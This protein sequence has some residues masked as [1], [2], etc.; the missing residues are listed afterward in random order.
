MKSVT[1]LFRGDDGRNYLFTFVLISTLFL[2]WGFCNSMIDI[3]DKH[4]QD[5]LHLTRAQSA[6]VQFSHY[7]GYFLIALPAGWLSRKLGYKGGILVGLGVVALGGFWFV[8]ATFIDT[9][10][11]FLLG[12][13]LL[14]MGLTFL[15]TVANPYATVLG[16]KETGASRIN[17]AQAC[18]GVGWIMGPLVGGMFFYGTTDVAENHQRLYIPYLGIGLVVLLLFVIFC[19]AKIPDLQ[20]AEI[21]HEEDGDEDVGFWRGLVIWKHGH[22]AMGVL[23]QFLYVA[24]QAGIFS[25]FINYIVAD[26]PPVPA[27]AG[28]LSWLAGGTGGLH[29]QAANG[30]HFFN[31]SGASKLFSC[32]FVLFFLGRFIGAL[33]MKR[34]PAHTVLGV[35]SVANVAMMILIFL[36]LGWTSVLALFLSFFFMSIMFPTIFALGIHGLGKK[37]KLASS[38]IVMAIMGGAIMPKVMGWMSDHFGHVDGYYGRIIQETASGHINTN[39][40]AP[41]FIVPLFS[42]IIIALY[43]F[44]WRKLSHTDAIEVSLN[45]GH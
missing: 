19:F 14:A 17:L 39:L 44:A 5:K 18:N 42:F 1:N 20:T 8:P 24:A 7:L 45:R 34:F 10:W 35:F 38:F 31:E 33:L 28:W 11:A 32:A 36:Q 26:T 3:M 12:V 30:L 4:F 29:Y 13:C 9:F 25:F 16:P 37:A 41:G 2:L 27:D 43:G 22:F 6:W 23:A 15:E 21:Y 40:M